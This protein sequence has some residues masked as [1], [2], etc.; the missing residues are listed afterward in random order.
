MA[1]VPTPPTP[2]PSAR[3]RSQVQRIG[4][5]T[6]ERDRAISQ[7]LAVKRLLGKIRDAAFE[8]SDSQT[9]FD[10]IRQQLA[11]D[12]D[13]ATPPGR[14][15][16]LM[17]SFDVSGKS[18]AGRVAEGVEFENGKVAMCWLGPTSSV[19][20]YDSIEDVV[21]IHGHGNSTE[22]VFRG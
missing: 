21:Q 2:V 1:S 10:Q 5:L 20:V 22:V 15:F 17:R 16:D 8:A 4:D 9:G 14:V 7:L 19:N 3:P 18:G 13:S 6:R 12:W 11:D